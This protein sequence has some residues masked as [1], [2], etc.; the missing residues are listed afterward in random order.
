MSLAKNRQTVRYTLP[1]KFLTVFSG[2]KPRT[3]DQWGYFLIAYLGYKVHKASDVSLR[4]LINWRRLQDYQIESMK[5]N[6]NRCLPLVLLPEGNRSFGKSSLI[7]YP[8]CLG[9]LLQYVLTYTKKQKEHHNQHVLEIG[10]CHK[11]ENM[12]LAAAK[13]R[14]G[15][16]LC[17]RP[18]RWKCIQ[19]LFC[20]D[21]AWSVRHLNTSMVQRGFKV[22]YM[23]L[24]ITLKILLS[25]HIAKI[26]QRGRRVVYYAMPR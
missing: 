14:I 3:P 15:K 20:I 8:A 18:L 19:V 25:I 12:V 5:P 24:G 4:Y 21:N 6:D 1:Y 13:N 22:Y 23:L 7:E 9:R 26:S 11:Y 10:L 16:N 2:G 17:T